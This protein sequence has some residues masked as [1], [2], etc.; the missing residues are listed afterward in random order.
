[1]KEILISSLISAIGS[2]GF[3]W[4]FTI[5]YTRKQ[6]EADAMKSVQD[7]YQT[8]V[9]DLKTEREELKE[10]ICELKETVAKNTNDI[11]RM[12][13]NLCGKRQC[14]DRQTF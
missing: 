11:Q 3:V 2:G 7:V 10:S 6:A 13:P 8:L 5:K 1:M 4:L 12:R 14:R 9:A